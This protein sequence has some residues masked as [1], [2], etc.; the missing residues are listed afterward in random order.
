MGPMQSWDDQIKSCFLLGLTFFFRV[1]YQCSLGT[2]KSKIYFLLGLTF[3]G[4]VGA[5][6]FIEKGKKRSF[7]GSSLDILVNPNVSAFQPSKSQGS[8]TDQS[9]H[10]CYKLAFLV[11]SFPPRP[12]FAT[13]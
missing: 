4:L 7:F 12:T 8:S 2:V 1:W 6:C 5:W 9:K 10:K 13:Q 3:F 11:V